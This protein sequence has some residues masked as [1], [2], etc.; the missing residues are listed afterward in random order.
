MRKFWIY[1]LSI[2]MYLIGLIGYQFYFEIETLFR[3]IPMLFGWL[4]IGLPA[5]FWWNDF[6]EKTFKTNNNG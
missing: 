2:S 4:F 6:F 3:F 5:T 1:V